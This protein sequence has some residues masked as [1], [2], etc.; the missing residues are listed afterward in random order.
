VSWTNNKEDRAEY[1][2]QLKEK[3]EWYDDVDVNEDMA[4]LL[5]DSLTVLN[6]LE[7]LRY[8]IG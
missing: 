8:M 4:N 6:E 5:R 7:A 2:R 3:I 1:R